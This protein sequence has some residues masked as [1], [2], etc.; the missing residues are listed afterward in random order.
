M[1]R[2][3][4]F[5]PIVQFLVFR[6]REDRGSRVI[7]AMFRHRITISQI[8]FEGVEEGY[9]S[10]LRKVCCRLVVCGHWQE[11][12]FDFKFD[13]QRPL[14]RHRDNWHNTTLLLQQPHAI[15]RKSNPTIGLYFSGRTVGYVQSVEVQQLESGSTQLRHSQ[16]GQEYRVQEILQAIAVNCWFEYEKRAHG[17]VSAGRFLSSER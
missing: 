1:F 4:S 14:A 9:S 6:I 11:T 13:H 15:R 17:P 8:V 2:S 7:L 5:C 3:Y 16:A 12:D 10:V